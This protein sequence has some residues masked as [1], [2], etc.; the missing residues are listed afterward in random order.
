MLKAPCQNL[1][2]AASSQ[3]ALDERRVLD[4][5]ETADSDVKT[6]AEVVVG[7]QLAFGV[8]TYLIKRPPEEDNASNLPGGMSETRNSHGSNG[9]PRVCF[10]GDFGFGASG[11]GL[12]AASS[13]S[14][15]TGPSR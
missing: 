14:A 9:Q 1:V 2:I 3:D 12:P 13:F 10:R 15:F 5:Q 7:W 8:Q 4:M 6:N 11:A